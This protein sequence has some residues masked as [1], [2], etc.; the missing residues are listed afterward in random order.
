MPT[1]HAKH[2]PSSLKNKH[3]DTGCS[4]WR[5]DPHADKTAAKAGTLQHDWMEQWENWLVGSR[6]EEP[7]APLSDEQLANAA[8]CQKFVEPFIRQA[9]HVAIENPL[10]IHIGGEEV[11]WGTADLIC[12]Q[13]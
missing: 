11:T 2:G 5:N 9:A 6:K 1:K 12:L 4:H 13:N 10:T 8:F 7:N 3:P